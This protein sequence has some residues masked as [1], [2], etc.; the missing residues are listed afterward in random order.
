MRLSGKYA[1]VDGFDCITG[2]NAS[3]RSSVTRYSASCSPDGTA[4]AEGNLDWTGQ[5]QG[6]GYLP[7]LPVED[8]LAFKGV[9][10]AGSVGDLNW[11]GD[12]LLQQTTL[13]LPIAAGTPITWSA[14]FGVQGALALDDA[15]HLLDPSRDPAPSA[16]GCKISI[17]TVIESN[18]FVDLAEVQSATIVFRR[19][20]VVSVSNGLTYREAGNLEVD[21]NF[22]INEANPWDYETSYGVNEIKRVRVYVTNSLFYLF[23]AIQFSEWGNFSVQRNPPAMIGF[24]VSGMWTALRTQTPAA[25]GQILLPG[26]DTLYPTEES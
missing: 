8:D 11:I 3:A 9:V 20:P 10:S 22:Q 13:N 25:L 1:Y 26:G 7:P 19:P 23:D 4:T 14:D 16:A 15:E 17:E 21:L 6:M 24:Q 12:I 2:W 5:M 18:T